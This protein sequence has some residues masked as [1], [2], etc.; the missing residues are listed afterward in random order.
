MKKIIIALFTV[1]VIMCMA[2]CGSQD[3]NSSGDG[4]KSAFADVESATK[5]LF[6]DKKIDGKY[7]F[8]E[9]GS[10]GTF[11]AFQDARL[12]KSVSKDEFYVVPLTK[13]DYETDIDVSAMSEKD[14][15]KYTVDSVSVADGKL[16]MELKNSELEK[17]IKL[18]LAEE[19]DA[20]VLSVEGHFPDQLKSNGKSI[21]GEN[22][23][24]YSDRAVA[25]KT[26]Y[27]AVKK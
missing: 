16:I 13:S 11:V 1:A 12:I 14:N 8:V 4:E 6:D 23:T 26:A 25:A 27:A 10:S 17:N 21:P 3:T 15:Y 18:T 2:A 9:Y 19:K 20:K 24:Y 7:F 5:Y 22:R